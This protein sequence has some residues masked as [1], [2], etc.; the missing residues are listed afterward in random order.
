MPVTPAKKAP[1]KRSPPAKAAAQVTITLTHVAA[2]LSDCHDTP[3][4]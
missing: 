3:K 4:K 2:A 1:A